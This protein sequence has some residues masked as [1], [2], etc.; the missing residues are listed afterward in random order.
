M[1]TLLIAAAAAASLAATAPAMAQPDANPY[2]PQ[3]YGTLGYSNY[4]DHSDHSAVQGRVGARFGRY[5]GVEGE[6]AGGVSTDTTHVYGERDHVKLNDQ[7]AGYA[8][9]YLPLRPNADPFAK[10]GYGASDAH[11]SGPTIDTGNYRS[12]I[13]YGAGGQYFF[14]GPNG[15]RA[16]YT[17]MNYGPTVGDSNVWSLAYVRK[18]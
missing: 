12:G 1:K 7:Y 10:V 11:I 2:G 6:L 14:S 9:G 5:F 8:V 4:D 15:V 3:F 16:D 13:A 17:R 18:F